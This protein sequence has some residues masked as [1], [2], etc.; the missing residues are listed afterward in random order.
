MA[1]MHSSTPIDGVPSIEPR[2]D[3]AAD[4][5]PCGNACRDASSCWK[6]L[7]TTV[8]APLSPLTPTTLSWKVSSRIKAV[9]PAT[10]TPWPQPWKVLRVMVAEPPSTSTPWELVVPR[11]Y[12]ESSNSDW[13]A[14][15]DPLNI[16]TPGASPP[17]EPSVWSTCVRTS[18]TLP[19]VRVISPGDAA[20]V[21]PDPPF[22]TVESVRDAEPASTSMHP[23]SAKTTWSALMAP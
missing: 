15:N 3:P 23:A 12:G 4:T 1:P 19:L 20:E 22:S 21:Q 13:S 9:P 10:P 17:G 7:R 16:R 8:T 18:D 11:S 5:V 14:V 6:V 2:T